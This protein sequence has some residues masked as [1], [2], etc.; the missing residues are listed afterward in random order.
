ME[1][2]VERCREYI[3]VRKNVSEFIV[4]AIVSKTAKDNMKTS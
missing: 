4:Q 1:R 3:R 2:E